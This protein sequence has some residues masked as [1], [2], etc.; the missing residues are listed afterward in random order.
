MTSR[1]ELEHRAVDVLARTLSLYK[2]SLGSVRV[3]DVAERIRRAYS[4]A[5]CNATK[6]FLKVLAMDLVELMADDNPA[7]DVEAFLFLCGMADAS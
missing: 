6:V 4:K 1:L 5:P 7:L 2:I 3:G